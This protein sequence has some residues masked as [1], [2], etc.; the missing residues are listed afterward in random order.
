[1]PAATAAAE[2]DDEPPGVC[3]GLRGLRVPAGCRL[4]NSVVTVLPS[5][6][7]PARRT[8]A[9]IGGIGFRAMAG[10][11]RRAVFGRE[12]DGVENVLDADRQPA[13]RHLRASPGAAAARRAAARSSATKAPISP[14]ARRSPAAQSSTTAARREFA[15]LDPAG[16][17]E[18]G[19]HQRR[20]SIRWTIRSVRRRRG[21]MTKKPVSAATGQAMK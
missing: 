7:P 1:M 13:Q 21:G 10:I 9:T 18:R 4:A 14:R 17:I 3:A 19:Q 12:I 16:E 11:D 2:P 5:T 8:S 15:G 20:P 6:M